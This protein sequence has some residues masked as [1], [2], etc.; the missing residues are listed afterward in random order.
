M[1]QPPFQPPQ[2]PGQSAQPPQQPGQPPQVGYNPYAQP[3]PPPQQP[4]GFAPAPLPGIA[5]V[6]VPGQYAV[7]GQ[8]LFQMGPGGQRPNARG[9]P[10]GAVFLGLAVSFVVALLYSGLIAATYKQQSDTAA[11]VLYFAHALLNGAVVGL[12]VGS[13]AR[14]SNG[15]RIGGAVIAA[16]GA[17]FGYANSIPLV[18]AVEETP[19]AA[20]DLLEYEPFLPAKLWWQHGS[21][22]VDWLN[23]L[24]LVVAAGVAWGIAY[25]VGKRRRQV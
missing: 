4:P 7:P 12:L 5:P 21:G 6:P 2:Q 3:V 25:A 1:S 23:V 13:M 9:N 18:F 22:G 8:A 20:F 10:V 16:L 17:F 11:N 19:K 15:A 14:G 24:G